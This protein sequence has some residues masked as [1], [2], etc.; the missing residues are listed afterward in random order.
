[1]G[2]VKHVWLLDEPLDVSTLADSVKDVRYGGVVTF[3][4]EVRSITGDLDTSKLIYEAHKGMA[5]AQMERIAQEAANRWDANVAVAHRIGE[6]LPGDVAVYCVAACAH[7]AE[8]FDCCR[9]LIDRIKEDVPIWKK[10]F[11]ASGEAWIAGSER[12]DR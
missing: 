9:H 2:E 11:G 3:S 7:R 1:V 5:L 4:G 8:A 12:V 6:L 10:E